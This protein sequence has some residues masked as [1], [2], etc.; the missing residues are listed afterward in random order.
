MNEP[1]SVAGAISGVLVTG[2]ALIAIFNPNL[3]QA[4]QVGIIAFGNSV[5]ILGTVLW[6]RGKSTPTAAPT[7]AQGTQVTVVTPGDAPNKTTTL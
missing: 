4:A 5:I 3:G 6:A 7:L 1:V 2:V